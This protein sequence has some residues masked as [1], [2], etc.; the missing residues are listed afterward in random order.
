M[1]SPRR[2]GRDDTYYGNDDDDYYDAADANDYGN[3]APGSL[4]SDL[5]AKV[6]IGGGILLVVF[7]IS[8]VALALGIWAVVTTSANTRKLNDATQSGLVMKH[9][10]TK[11]GQSPRWNQKTRDWE[12]GHGKLV[13]LEDVRLGSKYLPLEDG[14]RL[15]WHGNRLVNVRN[16]M[17][18]QELGHHLDVK[19]IRPRT[20]DMALYNGTSHQWQNVPFAAMLSLG[21]MHDVHL[22]SSFKTHGATLVYVPSQKQW[23][24][25]S[26]VAHAWIRFC[27]TVPEEW[28]R[29]DLNLKATGRKSWNAVFPHKHYGFF[30]LNIENLFFGGMKANR[31]NGILTSPPAYGLAPVRPTEGI[32][33][34]LRA[35]LTVT[36][37][38]QGILGFLV[39]RESAPADGGF[40]VGDDAAAVA[41]SSNST[42]QWTIE[43]VRMIRPS[44]EIQLVFQA[45]PGTSKDLPVP[46][47]QCLQISAQ[48]LS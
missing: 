22:D 6:W 33:F 24:V 38:P 25:R 9:Q 28:A 39:G 7:T 34:N 32:P 19:F 46:L 12:A 26:P 45:A 23:K 3:K 27:T 1:T 4:L 13:D 16:D 5:T 44:H 2:R 14:D 18:S 37:L 41:N 48:E 30:N 21:A 29:L 40:Q 36:N 47:I 15:A 17:V 42:K 8:V 11:M 10:P 35:T 20:G 43:T 31:Q